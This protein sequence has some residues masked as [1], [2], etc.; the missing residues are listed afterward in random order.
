[1]NAFTV[2]QSYVLLIGAIVLAVFIVRLPL[3]INDYR[4]KR[5]RKKQPIPPV[6]FRADEY[7]PRDGHLFFIGEK[8][9]EQ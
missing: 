3:L 8:T 1:M 9:P 4:H 6:W 5:S 7:T 2:T